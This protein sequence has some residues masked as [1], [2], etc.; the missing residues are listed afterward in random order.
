VPQELSWKAVSCT[1][2]QIV[3][4]ERCGNR[5]KHIAGRVRIMKEREFCR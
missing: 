3:V 2:G 4:R 5:A 1:W